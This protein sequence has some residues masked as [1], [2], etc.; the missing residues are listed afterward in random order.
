LTRIQEL[1]TELMLSD[2]RFDPFLKSTW[3]DSDQGKNY[4]LKAINEQNHICFV[5]EAE[6][7][8]IGYASCQLLT[9]ET[10]RLA[11]RAELDNLCVTEKYRSRGVGHQL[12]TAFKDWARNNGAKKIKVLSF[13]SNKDAIRFYKANGFKDQFLSME[14]DL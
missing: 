8:I 7:E 13:A 14:A 12:V 10:W 4:L 9:Q 5:A 2:R 11:P 1:G 6:G 3:Y